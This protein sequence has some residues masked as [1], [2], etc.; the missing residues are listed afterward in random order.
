MI[1]FLILGAKI[2][3]DA[4]HLASSSFIKLMIGKGSASSELGTYPFID[5]VIYLVGVCNPDEGVQSR[6]PSTL[7][8]VKTAKTT[9]LEPSSNSN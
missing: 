3:R 4:T 1:F 6:C 5:R 8:G 2:R 9:T 7:G